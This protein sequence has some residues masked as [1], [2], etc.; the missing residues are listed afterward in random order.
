MHIWLDPFLTL[1]LVDLLITNLSSFYILNIILMYY[2]L[3]PSPVKIP[4]IIF[5]MS[6]IVE[7]VSSYP[8]L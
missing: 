3:Y 5:P 2:L 7:P 8:F 4:H 1:N 6:F